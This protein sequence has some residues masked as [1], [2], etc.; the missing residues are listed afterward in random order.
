MR[1]A[2][3]LPVLVAGLV[4]ALGACSGSP[5]DCPGGCVEASIANFDLSCSPNDLTSVVATGP[6]ARPD[7]SLE[8]YT[9]TGS[10]WIVGVGSPSPG[11]CH[12]AL[13]FATG[14]TYSADVTFA[15]QPG[16]GCGCPS[17]VGPNP[18]VV[19]KVNNPSNTCHALPD[20]GGDQ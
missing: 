3:T 18:P 11:V 12:V 20:A 14:F 16:G 4:V 13:T 15:V 7:A 10:E 2:L 6:C 1:V 9:G 5:P 19:L 17:F 8:W